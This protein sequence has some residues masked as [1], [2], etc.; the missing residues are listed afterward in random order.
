MGP[1]AGL[2]VR[3]KRKMLCPCLESNPGSYNAKAWSLY[4][5]CCRVGSGRKWK[6]KRLPLKPNERV[7]ETYLGL[8]QIGPLYLLVK[9]GKVT[10]NMT[11]T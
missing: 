2:D 8:F 3:D 9:N 7:L 11:R 10:T 5:P 1:G 4:R 6:W